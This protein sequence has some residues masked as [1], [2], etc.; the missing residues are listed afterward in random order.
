MMPTK[1]TARLN[2]SLE[3]VVGFLSLRL[4]DFTRTFSPELPS[5]VLLWGS[6]HP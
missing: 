6:G 4:W 5:E 2:S 3:M 1:N